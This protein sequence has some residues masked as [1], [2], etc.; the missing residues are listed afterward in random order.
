MK[1]IL[2]S[3]VKGTGKK[4][5]IIEAADGYAKNF[6]LPRKLA[7]EATKEN[8]TSLEN[9]KKVLEKRRVADLEHAKELKTELEEKVI[10]ISVKI[11]EKGRLFGS[12]TNKEVAAELERQTG[13]I[14]DRKHIVIPEAI[15]SVGLRQVDIKLHASVTAKLNIDVTGD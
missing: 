14:I 3:D 8:M 5:Q 4:G 12:V 13:L 10:K 9:K 7:V 2:I 15:K 11:G 6:L 1:V